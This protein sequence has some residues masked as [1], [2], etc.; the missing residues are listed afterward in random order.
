MK[1]VAADFIA[2]RVPPGFD[3]GLAPASA[4]SLELIVWIPTAAK[5]ARQLRRRSRTSWSRRIPDS[6][7]S[8]FARPET[9]TADRVI[10]AS[11]SVATTVHEEPSS[12][13][14]LRPRRLLRASG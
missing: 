1:M 11:K 7:T 10:R 5:R 2:Q 12:R 9:D 13:S 14:P 6:P 8:V 4:L 3:V